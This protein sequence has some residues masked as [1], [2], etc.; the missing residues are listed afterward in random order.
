M[1]L[2]SSISKAV[3]HA[4]HKVTNGIKVGAHDLGHGISVTG[5]DLGHDLNSGIHQYYHGMMDLSSNPIGSIHSLLTGH[6]LGD[7]THGGG[8]GFEQLAYNAGNLMPKT[9]D[10]PKGT[11]SAGA[12]GVDTSQVNKDA[13]SLA[14]KNEAWSRGMGMIGNQQNAAGLNSA[15]AMG[16]L[17][18]DNSASNQQDILGK[19][20]RAGASNSG[21]GADF[22]R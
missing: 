20:K 17:M 6:S 13:A 1:G 10:M 15:R 8:T 22:I 11:A 3:S 19:I 4:V 16:S 18:A 2:F 12:T 5:K 14:N 7:K 21:R 9:P